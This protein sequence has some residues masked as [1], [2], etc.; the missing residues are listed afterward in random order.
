MIM[1][2]M[3]NSHQL[4]LFEFLHITEPAISIKIKKLERN[5]NVQVVS[6]KANKYTDKFKPRF[7]AENKTSK[8]PRDFLKMLV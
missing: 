2:A 8:F 5:P 1:K 4:K 7:I 6:E 3:I